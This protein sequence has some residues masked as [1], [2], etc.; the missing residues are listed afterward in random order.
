M[1]LKTSRSFYFRL[2]SEITGTSRPM[3]VKSPVFK[4]FYSMKGET[5]ELKCPGQY[6]PNA[7]IA[8]YQKGKTGRNYLCYSYLSSAS[9]LKY[10]LP[11]RDW[12][13]KIYLSKDYNHPCTVDLESQDIPEVSSETEPTEN[14]SE[15]IPEVSSETEPTEKFIVQIRKKD[16]KSVVKDLKEKGIAVTKLSLKPL[17][18]IV[19]TPTEAKRIQ[20]IDG[21]EEVMKNIC[22]D[23]S[24]DN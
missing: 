3:I 12:E 22:L 23:T 10:T 14:E 7:W 5:M 17:Y 24:L 11:K 13:F 15:L 21:V 8:L 18:G 9:V 16:E 2:S 4:C 19:V 20:E 6:P 1:Y